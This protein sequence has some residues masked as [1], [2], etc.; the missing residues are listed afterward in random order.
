VQCNQLLSFNWVACPY[1]GTQRR[2]GA[3]P[4]SPPPSVAKATSTQ[5][6]PV[7]PTSEGAAGTTPKPQTATS[8]RSPESVP[9]AG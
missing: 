4:T 8:R 1:C 3:I 6:S 9:P 7:T 5:A 2:S